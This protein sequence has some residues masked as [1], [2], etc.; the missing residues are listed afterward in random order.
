MNPPFAEKQT[1]KCK[2]KS[3]ISGRVHRIPENAKGFVFRLH[4]EEPQHLFI[5]EHR[6]P[7]LIAMICVP[8]VYL[9]LH[10]LEEN[11]D[12]VSDFNGDP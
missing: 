10:H 1:N 5:A 3:T 6:K 11:S 2:V 8:M 12:Q 7:L 9:K 4:A